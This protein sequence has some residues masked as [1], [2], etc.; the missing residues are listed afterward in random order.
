MRKSSLLAAGFALSIALVGCGSDP[1]QEPG[2]T[3]APSSE[4]LWADGWTKLE[5]FANYARTSLDN[6][7]HFNTDRNACYLPA[8]G[9]MK[10]DEWN[11]VT[12]DLN[13][14]VQSTRLTEPKC[15]DLTPEQSRNNGFKFDGTADLVLT[16]GSKVMLFEYRNWSVCSHIADPK[17]HARL[18]DRVNSVVM[19]AD[20]EDCP[21]PR[22][23][24]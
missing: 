19:A 10:L 8:F 17:L 24:L 2:E 13:A 18:L 12:G 7:A 4:M 5:I 22:G 11:A 16:D 1:A 23:G 14:F 15:T 6:A 9:A 3:P 20:K 21:R